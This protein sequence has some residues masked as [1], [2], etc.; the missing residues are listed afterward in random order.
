L[1]VHLW[2]MD[3]TEINEFWEPHLSERAVGQLGWQT[4]PVAKATKSLSEHHIVTSG[5]NGAF[6]LA[7]RPFF[8]ISTNHIASLPALFLITNLR[9]SGK[10]EGKE[11]RQGLVFRR[12]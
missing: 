7:T 6:P 1:R 2:W 10:T 12:D 5:L 8:F 3:E 4:S 9:W 11:V